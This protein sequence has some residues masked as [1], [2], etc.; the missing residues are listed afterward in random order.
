MPTIVGTITCTEPDSLKICVRSPWNNIWKFV[1]SLG[2]G[3]SV[4]Q[5]LKYSHTQI[6]SASYYVFIFFISVFV[7]GS[8]YTY[9]IL[10]LFHLLDRY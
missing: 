5:L 1:I 3:Q 6:F 4:K 7:Y 8:I 10:I 9:D 2:F